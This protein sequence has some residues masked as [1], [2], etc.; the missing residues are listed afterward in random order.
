LEENGLKVTDAASNPDHLF[1]G[2][3]IR[4]V[5]KEVCGGAFCQRGVWAQLLSES[6]NLNL[7]QA[8]M[9]RVFAPSFFL[10][11]GIIIPPLYFLDILVIYRLVVVFTID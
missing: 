9:I 11:G 2:V 3:K 6:L 7:Y 10:E 8:A 1:I 5:Y 4:M